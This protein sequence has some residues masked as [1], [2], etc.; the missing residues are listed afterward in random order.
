MLRGSSASFASSI[1]HAST[2]YLSGMETSL[3]AESIE[4]VRSIIV[5]EPPVPPAHQVPHDEL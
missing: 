3:S 5:D 2:P 1:E 4:T